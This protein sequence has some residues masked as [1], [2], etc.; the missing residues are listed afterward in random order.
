MPDC[1]HHYILGEP[2]EGRL[3]GKCKHC[4]AEKSWPSV[5]VILEAR[6]WILRDP[7]IPRNDIGGFGLLIY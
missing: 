3:P 4:G 1:T 6:P 7:L 5:G 2:V